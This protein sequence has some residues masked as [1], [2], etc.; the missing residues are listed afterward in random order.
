MDILLKLA[1]MQDRINEWFEKFAA[2][3]TH[4]D[5]AGERQG[6]TAAYMKKQEEAEKKR[7]EQSRKYHTKRPSI[8]EKKKSK[9]V[10]ECYNNKTKKWG[11]CST[12]KPTAPKKKKE[13][14]PDF[15]IKGLDY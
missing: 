3:G 1:S 7:M 5:P 10:E 6:R 8:S 15:R 4:K 9:T 13:K 2:K 14:T 11:P 12:K